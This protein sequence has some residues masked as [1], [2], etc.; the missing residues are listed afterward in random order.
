[1]KNWINQKWNANLKC[2]KFELFK[3]K[4]WDTSI[5]KLLHS[6]DSSNGGHTNAITALASMDDGSN[7]LASGSSDSTVKIW[8]LSMGA[9][10]YS[11]DSSNG[12]HS[13]LV[14][15]L[16]W[17]SNDLIASG[18]YDS[19]VRIWDVKSG[20]LKA[21]FNSG[22]DHQIRF[23]TLIDQGLLASVSFDSSVELWA[24]P[25]NQPTTQTTLPV[26]TTSGWIA[27]KN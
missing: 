6:F 16:V 7:L 11:F 10:K 9:L 1:M 26:T 18:S 25:S 17:C 13:N 2:L 8:D 19:S 14:S 24:I 22:Q 12:G 21:V 15:A 27:L 4:I 20:E 23:L 5:C 3:I